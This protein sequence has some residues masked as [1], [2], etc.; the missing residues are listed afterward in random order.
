MIKPKTKRNAIYY[1]LDGQLTMAH[2]INDFN[3]ISLITAD[4]N[5]NSI[6]SKIAVDF[7][8]NKYTDYPVYKNDII[9]VVDQDNKIYIKLFGI[10]SIEFHNGILTTLDFN[11]PKNRINEV[12][13]I[14]PTI[15]ILPVILP[16]FKKQIYI[17][18]YQ[19]YLG[20]DC[21]Y[22][23]CDFFPTKEF[24]N[25]ITNRIYNFF[26]PITDEEYLEYYFDTLL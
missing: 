12:L 14:T 26:N 17:V 20:F 18:K 6:N 5:F 3:F 15:G 2:S 13:P 16:N 21:D 19:K 22:D 9:L 1:E 25:P 10:S 23:Y 4:K 8:G 11:I 24:R 7:N